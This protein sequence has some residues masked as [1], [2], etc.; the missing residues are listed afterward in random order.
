MRI[1]LAKIIFLRDFFRLCIDDWREYMN[2][3][4]RS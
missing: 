1:C 3:H 2:D 4:V